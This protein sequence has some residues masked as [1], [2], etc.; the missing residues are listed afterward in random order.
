[1]TCIKLESFKMVGVL[2]AFCLIPISLCYGS[3][4]VFLHHL[5]TLFLSNSKYCVAMIEI[6]NDGGN[7]YRFSTLKTMQ[8]ATVMVITPMHLNG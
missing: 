5:H 3:T 6:D 2:S 7:R 1:M 8:E 4:A